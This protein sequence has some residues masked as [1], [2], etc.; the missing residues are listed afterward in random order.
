MKF[1]ALSEFKR[2]LNNV[3]LKCKNKYEYKNININIS[4]KY[5]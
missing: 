1:T 2:I 3:I 4:I 5:K